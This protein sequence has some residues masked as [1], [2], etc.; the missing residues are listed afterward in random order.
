M[1]T[2]L[3]DQYTYLHFGVGI[4]TYFWGITIYTWII[5]HTL[6]EFIENTELGMYIINNIIK[7]W[8]GGKPK[9]DSYMN[10]LG[11][12]IGG[13][14]GWLSAYQVDKIGNNYNWYDLHMK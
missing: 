8:P 2:K 10:I 5:I 6:F 14:L 12:T 4:I 13:L 1:G 3:F 7:I 11:D 9:A